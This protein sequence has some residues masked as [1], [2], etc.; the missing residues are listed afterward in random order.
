MKTL[1]SGLNHWFFIHLNQDHHM[2]IVGPY[3]KRWDL[4]PGE[5]RDTK[6]MVPPDV[7]CLVACKPHYPLVIC[8]SEFSH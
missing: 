3:R 6:N 8:Y 1:D 2:G 4:Y 7:K 5:K